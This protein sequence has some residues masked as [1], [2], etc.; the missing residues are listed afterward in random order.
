M[1]QG[2]IDQSPGEA[3][4]RREIFWKPNHGFAAGTYVLEVAGKLA[5]GKTLVNR[6]MVTFTEYAATQKRIHGNCL[7][8]L[9][10]IANGQPVAGIHI[11]AIGRGNEL[12]AESVTDSQRRR[13]F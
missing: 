13:G 7:L 4:T 5:G 9:T 1:A 3:D 12:L 6:A 8:R 2:K 10:Q 11:R